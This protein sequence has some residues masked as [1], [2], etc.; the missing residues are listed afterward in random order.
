MRKELH[1][2]AYIKEYTDL[3][4]FDNTRKREYVEFR[5]LYNYILHNI[6]KKSLTWIRNNYIAN[7][8]NYDHATVIHSLKMFDTYQKYNPKIMPLFNE[9]CKGRDSPAEKIAFVDTA[10]RHMR[11]D[12]VEEVSSLVHE[13]LTQ[14][15][16]NEAAKNIEVQAE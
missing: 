6:M 1:L 11:K 8:K 12:E 14:N 9:L 15:I 13:L 2:A 5:A 4:I 3:D 16:R 10:L 7:G